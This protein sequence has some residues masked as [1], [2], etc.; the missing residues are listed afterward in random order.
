MK[1]HY[2]IRR[3]KQNAA[4]IINERF[5]EA[6]I[7]N[8]SRELWTEVKRIR[9]CE[10][11]PTNVMDGRDTP[12]EISSFFAK[13]YQDLC[14]SVS[15]DPNCMNDIFCELDDLLAVTGY[16]ENCIITSCNVL[17]DICKLNPARATVMVV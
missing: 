1:C 15:Y 13:K 2:A 16:N 8:K 12:A 14:T 6:V 7:N 3:I 5:A 17:D 4:A 10:A 9:G 11:R